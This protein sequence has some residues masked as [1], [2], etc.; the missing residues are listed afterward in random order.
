MTTTARE[1][2]ER[3][4]AIGPQTLQSIFGVLHDE[5]GHATTRSGARLRDLTDVRAFLRELM[6]EV[7][8]SDRFMRP[9]PREIRRELRREEQRRYKTGTE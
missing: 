3:F 1:V 9:G 5:L 2:A 4:R 6:E 8:I 7:K